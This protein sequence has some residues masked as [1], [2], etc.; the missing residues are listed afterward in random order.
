MAQKQK[1]QPQ[2]NH[3]RIYVLQLRKAESIH[4]LKEP[5][6]LMCYYDYGT[7]RT[8]RLHPKHHHPLRRLFFLL[9]S[10]C[11]SLLFLSLLFYSLGTE[12]I[13]QVERNIQAVPKPPCSSMQ[14]NSICC[15]RTSIRTDICFMR[16]DVRTNSRSSSILLV[17]SP[18]TSNITEEKIR[19]YTR[20]WEAN[21]MST[22]DELRL[23]Q[24][25]DS[26]FHKCDVTHDVPAVV[27]STGGYTG[28]V[29]H[30]FNDGI[31][32]LYITSQHFNRKVVFLILEYHDWWITKYGD[33]VSR[34][35]KYKPIDFTNDKR[36]H[37]F[38]EVI[39][40]VRIHDELTVDPKKM[41]KGKTI[42]DF[43]RM[44]DDAYKGRIKYI[45][46][47]DG[48]RSLV[49]VQY[50]P[51]SSTSEVYRPKLVFLSRSGGSRMI[52]NE[53]ELVAM[54][55]AIGFQVQVLKPDR[56]TELCKIYRELNYS[57]A[58]IG[59]HGA[60]MT[61]F[62]FMRPGKV[63]IQIIPLGTDWAAETYYGQPATK[64]GL[65][66]MPYKIQ[67]KES[68]LYREYPKGD[69]VLTDPESVGKRGWEVTKKVYLD[70]QNVRLDLWR[71]RKRLVRAHAYLVAK[72]RNQNAQ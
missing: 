39:V 28:N 58:M 38:K 25:A 60:A 47:I 36:T 64:L 65:W 46:R 37:C 1:Q 49:P 5:H 40:G 41:I 23:R 62:L 35:S 61:H 14:N 45:E 54:A 33:V 67:A 57:D 34:L 44:L 59:V 27:F 10:L 24:V 17:S 18:A 13:L 30:E 53:A 19:P 66:Y 51:T 8:N 52:E 56:T 26:R 16:G 2:N 63:F 7:G 6:H 43:R 9:S 4:C 68:S 31:L 69:P 72:K 20:K 12:Q 50:L 22:I 3:Q 32:P 70:R 11:F 29:Y 42:R 55:K 71:F 21:V 15:D 48:R